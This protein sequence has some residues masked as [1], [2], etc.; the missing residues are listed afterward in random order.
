MS[1]FNHFCPAKP[2]VLEHIEDRVE[3]QPCSYTSSNINGRV[4]EINGYR[5]WGA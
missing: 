1:P 4:L 5:G 2:A 3:R